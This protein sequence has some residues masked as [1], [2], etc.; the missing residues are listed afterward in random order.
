[1]GS[2]DSSPKIIRQR[3]EEICDDPVPSGIVILGDIEDEDRPSTRS[4]RQAAFSDRPEV[5]CRDAVKHMAYLDKEIIPKL[6]PL[7]TTTYGIMG[8]L[9]GHHWTWITPGVLNSVQYI[10]AQLGQLSRRSVPYLGQ[11]SAAIALLF[12][13]QNGRHI[14][15]IVH[16]QH[17]EGGGSTKGSSLAKLDRTAQGV[18]ADVYIRAHDCQLVATKNPRLKLK[19]AGPGEH[20]DYLARDVAML[21]LGSATQGYNMSREKMS[22]IE[23]KMMRPTTMGWGTVEFTLR[24][25]KAWEDPKRSERIDLKIVI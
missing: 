15:K 1:M 22:Y 6:L 5:P 23:E 25:S 19:E 10:C 9:A 7:Q 11:M 21:N 4:I 24:R 2:E 16:V 3:I 12:S 17:G 20:P 18:D 13:K 8:V 14:R